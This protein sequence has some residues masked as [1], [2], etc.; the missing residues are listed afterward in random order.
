MPVQ[1]ALVV[2]GGITGSVTAV[3]LARRG[4]RVH[5]IERSPRWFGVGHGI[6]VH[7]N[8]LRGL[9]EIG[10]ADRVIAQGVPFD[11]IRVHHADGSL[12]SDVPTPKTGGGDLPA[13]LGTLR[14]DLQQVLVQEIRALDVRV[15]LGMTAERLE[16]R[17]DGVDVTFSDGTTGSYDLVVGADGI[18]SSTRAALDLPQQPAPS[19]MGIWRF[20][21]ERLPHMDSSAV[22]YG[23]PCY[24]AGY[25]PISPTRCY[26][27]VLIDPLAKPDGGLEGLRA[28]LTDYHGD[29][30][31]L[32][33]R[34]DEGTFANYQPVEWLLVDDLWACGRVVLIGDAVHACPPLIAQGA[35]MCIEDAVLLAEYVTAPGLLEEQLYRFWERR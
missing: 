8:A 34:I 28:L 15:S 9:A 18:R 11:R 16:Q 6:T 22:F 33:R 26:A 25:A 14:A 30:D 19:G 32:R 20:V 2:G 35:A 31:H 4:V 3:A 10:L 21:T 24:K 13:T 12:L 1:H 29:F 23:G 17:P 7:G 27:Y 5:L